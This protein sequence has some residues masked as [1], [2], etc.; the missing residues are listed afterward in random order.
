MACPNTHHPRVSETVN[1]SLALLL[2]PLLDPFLYDPED[3]PRE[4]K[5]IRE[6]L[7]EYVIRTTRKV[8]ITVLREAIPGRGDAYR[9][10]LVDPLIGEVLDN[11][12]DRLRPTEVPPG[13]LHVL[14][15]EDHV[16]GLV[17]GNYLR[18][19]LF[20]CRA[21]LHFP[22]QLAKGLHPS[23]KAVEEPPVER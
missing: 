6:G 18:Q 10:R 13:L 7:S 9:P 15:H 11:A 12:L 3:F 17:V 5:A 22:V 4:P 16:E 14:V 20:P 1:S 2:L 21:V 19:N 8:G 23:E